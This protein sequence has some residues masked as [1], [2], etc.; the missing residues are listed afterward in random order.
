MSGSGFDDVR[1]PL[2]IG[3]GASVGVQWQTEIVSLASGR[4]VRN[5]RWAASRRRWDV[6][7]AAVSGVD[8]AVLSAFFEARRG[9]LRGFRFRDPSDHSSAP[10]G[11]SFGR[12]RCVRR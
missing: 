11:H 2:P 7:S 1:F 10:A 3:P 6:A 8:L 9:R 4:E 12:C 5:A